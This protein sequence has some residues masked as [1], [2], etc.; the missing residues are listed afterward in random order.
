MFRKLDMDRP[1]EKCKVIY[2]GSPVFQKPFLTFNTANKTSVTSMVAQKA[3]NN[4]TSI[5][6]PETD[7][8]ATQNTNRFPLLQLSFSLLISFWYVLRPFNPTP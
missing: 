4:T 6:S 3:E 5:K 2:L 7:P 8:C 1:L